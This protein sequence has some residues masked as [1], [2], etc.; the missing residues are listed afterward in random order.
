MARQRTI[1][2]CDAHVAAEMSA[3]RGQ[4]NYGNGLTAIE[5]A[6]LHRANM[7]PERRAQLDGEW[8]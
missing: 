3:W 1:A 6:R 8:L 2:L 4:H 5:H 7:S